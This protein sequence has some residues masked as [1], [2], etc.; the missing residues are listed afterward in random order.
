MLVES[1][2]LAGFDEAR[3]SCPETRQSWFK[4]GSKRTIGRGYYRII[5]IKNRALTKKN[6]SKFAATRPHSTI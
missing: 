3:E 6:S 4:V 1:I 2:K 5:E